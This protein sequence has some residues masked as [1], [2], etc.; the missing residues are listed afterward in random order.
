MIRAATLRALVLAL[1][2]LVVRPALAADV[3][4]A[5]RCESTGRRVAAYADEGGLGSLLQA[6]HTERIKLTSELRRGCVQ[7]AT[8]D[9]FAAIQVQRSQVVYFDA[10]YGFV[11]W[12]RGFRG[13]VERDSLFGATGLESVRVSGEQR[14]RIGSLVY[15][16][17]VVEPLPLPPAK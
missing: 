6:L 13:K 5:E 7:V 17:F 16:A 10:D 8:S 2:L 15:R 9:M 12:L 4:F 11:F 14:Y 1:G 3:E